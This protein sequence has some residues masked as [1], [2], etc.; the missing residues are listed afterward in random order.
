MDA[1]TLINLIQ[2][3]LSQREMALRLAITHSKLRRLLIKHQLRTQGQDLDRVYSDF[4]SVC[5]KSIAG[6]MRNRRRCHSCNTRI[7]RYRAKL[8]AVELGG[9]KCNRCGWSGD[10]AA[11]EFH[12]SDPSEKKF[13]IGSAANKSWSVIK[14]EVEK[15]EL[16]CSNCHRIEHSGERC[17]NF[18]KEVES[19]K[20]N[21]LR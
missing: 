10:I 6:N 12:H 3:G 2:E 17:E 7:R 14:K 1:P 16:L 11:Y 4:C 19:Y 8:A 15:C 21:T 9:G 5:K 18:M 13:A 20:G